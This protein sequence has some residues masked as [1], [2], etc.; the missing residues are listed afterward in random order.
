MSAPPPAP[1][2][3]AVA[4]SRAE[5][6]DV[7]TNSRR[8]AAGALRAARRGARLV[9]LPELHLSGYDLDA[10]AAAAVTP[11]DPRLDPIREAGREVTVV[12]GAPVARPDGS[13]ANAL[14][15]A[16]AAGIRVAYEKRH[17]WHDERRHFTPGTAPGAVTVDGWRLGL[18]ICYDLSFPEHARASA[19]G[20][21]HAY[22]VAGAFAAGTE[23]RAAVYL[24]ARALE[25]TV[26]TAF[27][28]PVGGPA[29]RPC[30][31]AGSVW[32]PDG[33]RI[34]SAGRTRERLLVADL[35]PASLARVRGFLRMLAEVGGPGGEGDD[36]VDAAT[37][38]GA[39]LDVPA[40]RP[41][42]LVHQ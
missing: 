5:P 10:V 17:L 38:G 41:G 39:Q 12:V 33:A 8:A 18:G 14:L 16:D 35:D 31:G 11:D 19:V 30:A 26:F 32:A 22:L 20:G 4:Q 21:A 3:L 25:N 40:A 29:H 6:G 7:P 2:R 1:L 15:V 9:L 13:L 23:H 37:L 24:A 34:A 28:N 36:R 42:Q 27:A